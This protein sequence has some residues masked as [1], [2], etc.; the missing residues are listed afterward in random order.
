MAGH[1]GTWRL[2]PVPVPAWAC[3]NTF[4]TLTVTSVVRSRMPADPSDLISESVLAG[5]PGEDVQTRRLAVFLGVT[6]AVSWSVA[7]G[8]YAMGGLAGGPAVRP[9][10]G[11][12][13]SSIPAVQSGTT[14]PLDII[15]DIIPGTFLVDSWNVQPRMTIRSGSPC[16]TVGDADRPPASSRPGR[17]LLEASRCR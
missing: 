3:V 8:I 12:P 17:S 6:F 13:L 5:L 14:R 2:R 15:P 10:E 16:P 1:D 11:T 7:G 9:V 4:Q